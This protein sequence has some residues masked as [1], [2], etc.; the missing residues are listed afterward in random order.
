MPVCW[1]DAC[2]G[3]RWQDA[4]PKASN[5]RLVMFIGSMTY[6][7]TEIDKSAV[8]LACETLSRRAALAQWPPAW[9]GW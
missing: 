7:A 8:R 6:A 9:V 3:E 5:H 1:W 4:I 2:T